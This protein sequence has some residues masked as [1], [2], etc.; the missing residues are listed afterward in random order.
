[1]YQILRD[2]ENKKVKELKKKKKFDQTIS[3]PLPPTLDIKK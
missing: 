2:N 3:N 1:M